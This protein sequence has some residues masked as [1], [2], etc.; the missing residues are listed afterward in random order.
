MAMV[1]LSTLVKRF[2]V[3]SVRDFFLFVQD[4]F[5][6]IVKD[7]QY[8]NLLQANWNRDR[9]T[10]YIGNILTSPLLYIALTTEPFLQFP[11]TLDLRCPQNG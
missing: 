3:S 1:I 4:Q 5:L 7:S 11:I 2:S 6:Q 8:D 10:F 9:W